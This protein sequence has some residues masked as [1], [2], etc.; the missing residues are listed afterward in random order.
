MQKTA[1]MQQAAFNLIIISV[2]IIAAA[3]L[4]I[5]GKDAGDSAREGLLLCADVVIPALFPFFVISS[6]AIELGAAQYASFLTRPFMRGVFNL[7]AACAPAFILGLIGGYPVGAKTAVSIYEKGLCTKAEAEHMLA[8]C[9][10]SGPAFILGVVGAGIFKSAKIGIILYLAHA[11]AAI[12]VG[13]AFRFY[14]CRERAL[15]S[16]FDSSTYTTVRLS[17]A[18]I[19]A[20]NSA[21]SSIFGICSFVVI[22]SV[23]IRILCILNVIPFIARLLTPILTPFGLSGDGARLLTSGFFEVTSGLWAVSKSADALSIRIALSAFMLGWSGISVHCQVLSFTGKTDL[24]IRPYF[25]GK[26][27]SAFLSVLYS[28]AFFKISPISSV[29]VSAIANTSFKADAVLFSKI[30]SLSTVSCVLIWNLLVLL[31]R[32]LRKIRRKT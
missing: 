17:D 18:F 12:T 25:A 32:L 4:I 9:N 2:L 29:T 23:I 16:E 10:N 28:L 7:N 1:K 15:P 13:F 8:F 6:L 11:S 5:Y 14:K 24:S 21:L 20:V 22:F 26:L 27:L 31:A 30:F 19:S 3:A